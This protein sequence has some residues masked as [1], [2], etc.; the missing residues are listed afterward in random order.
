MTS[1]SH[2]LL[3]FFI[4]PF[5]LFFLPTPF[6]FSYFHSVQLLYNNFLLTET[7]PSRRKEGN[8]ET[9]E[10]DSL[11]LFWKAET[12]KIPEDSSVATVA[13]SCHRRDSDQPNSK[14]MLL[15]LQKMPANVQHCKDVA[16]RSS[17]PYCGWLCL[18]AATLESY[19][20]L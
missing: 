3:S 17:H 20:L 12:W 4:F 15:D 2:F 7:F 13:F 8:P 11:L 5:F 9:Q 19:L 18:D 1:L 16:L 14:R 10:V 6:I